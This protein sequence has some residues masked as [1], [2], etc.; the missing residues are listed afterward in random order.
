MNGSTTTRLVPIFTF[1]GGVL[2]AQCWS[3]VFQTDMVA[4]HLRNNADRLVT[5]AV[6]SGLSLGNAVGVTILAASLLGAFDPNVLGVVANLYH[7]TLE[8]LVAWMWSFVLRAFIVEGHSIIIHQAST[9]PF[10]STLLVRGSPHKSKAT[11]GASNQTWTFVPNHELDVNATRCAPAGREWACFGVT[12]VVALVATAAAVLAG[13]L[14]DTKKA[15]GCSWRAFRQNL[16]WLLGSLRVRS[17]PTGFAWFSVT[18]ELLYLYLALPRSMTHTEL[19]MVFTGINIAATILHALLGGLLLYPL[20]PRAADKSPEG[21]I[22]ANATVDAAGSPA[23]AGTTGTPA[24]VDGAETRAVAQ[25][26]LIS[27][28]L[29]LQAVKLVR[30]TC[31]MGVAWAVE[32]LYTPLFESVRCQFEG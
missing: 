21:A 10:D 25:R 17:F 15:H 31:E 18:S 30:K 6:I 29:R 20:E 2:L 19:W 1:A 7:E 23:V 26:K 32:M 4:V 16:C 12:L 13:L 11:L 14:A 9:K 24:A 5:S 8:L 22:V 28:Q 27:S 3:D